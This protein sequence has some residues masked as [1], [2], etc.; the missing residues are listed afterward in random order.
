[1]LTSQ[2]FD[3]V[4]R[5]QEAERECNGAVDYWTTIT[6]PPKCL[7]DVV[8]AYVA[9][10]FVDSEFDFAVVQ[11]FFDT[12]LKPFF[13]DM[14]IYDTFANQHP[15]TRLARR[16]ET[17]L[18]CTQ[19]RTATQITRAVLPSDKDRV[20]AMLMIHDQIHFSDLATSP[21]YARK[22]VAEK[23]LEALDGLPEFEFRKRFG[24]DCCDEVTEAVEKSMM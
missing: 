17:E 8:E 20:V 21:R 24:C 19:W 2:I 14:Y 22:R 23:A 5:V 18:G 13:L 12:H 1:M 7:A 15:T 16:L 3:Y 4:T 6:E 10:I 9:A 11:H